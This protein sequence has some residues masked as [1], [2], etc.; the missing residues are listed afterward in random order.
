MR[1]AVSPS[2]QRLPH[3]SAGEL[4]SQGPE[5][6]NEKKLSPHLVSQIRRTAPVTSMAWHQV[7]VRV[8]GEADGPPKLLLKNISGL[9]VPGDMVALLG[10]SG[11][12]PFL[13]TMHGAV[14]ASPH[15]RL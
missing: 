10:P 11:E 12:G 14:P 8:R 9:A 13:A 2:F 7:S 15:W 4:E 6:A 3:A 5:T 1:L